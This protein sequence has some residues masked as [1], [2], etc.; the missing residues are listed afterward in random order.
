MQL[1]LKKDI[2]FLDFETTGLSVA[3]SK[4]IQIGTLKVFADGRPNETK[5]RLVNPG[6]PIPEKIQQ[7]TRITDEMVKNQPTFEKIAKKFLE[8]IGDCDIAGFN[9]IVYDIPLLKQELYRVG[10][11]LDMTVRHHID[12]KRIYHRFEA[13]KLSDAYFFYCNEKMTDAHDSGA[14]VTATY[15]VLEAMLDRYENQNLEEN[16][17]II[18]NPIIN[19][20][21]ALAEFTKT[22]GAIDLAKKFILDENNV[23]IFNFGKYNRLPV[24][25]VLTKDKSYYDWIMTGVDKEDKPSFTQDTRVHLEKIMT[26]YRKAQAEK[27]E[28]AK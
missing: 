26:N 11:D 7:I 20:V 15:K 1:N 28:S 5:V 16:S 13:R 6:I 18:V 24:A 9:S 2:I 25:E 14:D 19:D 3:D 27:A 17:E 10:L 21:A 8:Y 4:I 22:I 23:P 12:V